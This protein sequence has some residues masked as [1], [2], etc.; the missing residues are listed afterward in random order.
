MTDMNIQNFTYFLKELRKNLNDL[1]SL[2]EQEAK[3]IQNLNVVHSTMDKMCNNWL[4][5]LEHQ[6]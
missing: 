1:K 3:R 4:N 2:N 6:K 5:Q